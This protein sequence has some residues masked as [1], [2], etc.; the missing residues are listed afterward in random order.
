MSLQSSLKGAHMFSHHQ[1][2]GHR[3]RLQRGLTLIE[4]MI[5]IAILGLLASVLVVAVVNQ[6]DDARIDAASVKLKS[7]E[8]AVQMYKVKYN[9][10]PSQ[11]EGLRA[12]LNPPKNRKPL[13]KSEKDI[14]DPWEEEILYFSPAKSSKA[15]FE[16]VSKGP[17]KQQGTDDDISNND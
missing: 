4:V 7:I 15:E 11:A 5:V 12:L 16:L 3:N 14:K 10:V 9:R 13:L 17:D 6:L 1:S 8:S 2:R